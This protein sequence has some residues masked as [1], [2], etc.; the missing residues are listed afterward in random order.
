MWYAVDCEQV[1]TGLLG[2]PANAVSAAGYL[3]AGIW[4]LV[5][6][7][8]RRAAPRRYRWFAAAVIAN[9]VGSG[10]Y[11]GTGWSGSGWCHD[12]AAIAVPVFVAA[13]GFGVVRGWEDRIVTRVGLAATAAVAVAGLIG[14]ATNLALAA[15][16]VA[17]GV[18]EALVARRSSV[19]GGAR[20]GRVVMVAA[21]GLGAAAYALGRT[22]GPL[23]HPDSLLQP[24]ALWHLLT[25]LAMVVW[26]VDRMVDPGEVRTRGGGPVEA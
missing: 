18:A 8:R 12:V 24:H 5:S 25:A 4:L 7:W 23:C 17:A 13:D 15:A 21:L 10:L 26:A 22:G 6:V 20:T 11:H 14:P 3:V 19:R 16:L 1:R 9:G 2:Q